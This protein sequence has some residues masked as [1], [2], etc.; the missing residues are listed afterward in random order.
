MSIII[1]LKE[2]NQGFIVL[3]HNHMLQLRIKRNDI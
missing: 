3:N 2:N 1:S